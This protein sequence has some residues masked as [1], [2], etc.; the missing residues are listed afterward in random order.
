MRAS[1]GPAGEFS[2]ARLALFSLGAGSLVLLGAAAIILL[3]Q[4]SPVI[5]LVIGL[6]GLGASVAAVGLVSTTMTRRALGPHGPEQRGSVKPGPS[7]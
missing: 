3:A 1:E 2:M 6:V 7:D 4:P 5:G